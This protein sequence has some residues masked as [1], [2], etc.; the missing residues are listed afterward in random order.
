MTIEENARAVRRWFTE[1]W[2]GNLDLAEEIFSPALRTNGVLVGTDGPKQNN[3][4]R[5]LGFPD[6]QA[7]IDDLIPVEDRVVVRLHWTGTHTGTY[8]GVPATGRVVRVPGLAIWRFEAGRVVEIWS[9]QDQFALLQQI[10]VIAP[11]ISGAQVH[12][13]SS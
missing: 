1:G 4:N 6:V 3:R 5:L 9:V 8:S 13:R 2:T 7:V 11:E 10:G 12:A